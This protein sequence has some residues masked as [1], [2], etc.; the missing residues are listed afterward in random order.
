MS[1]IPPGI[2]DPF[3]L[4]AIRIGSPLMPMQIQRC[5]VRVVVVAGLL[6]SLFQAERLRASSADEIRAGVA[7]VCDAGQ[8]P[9][10]VRIDRAVLPRISVMLRRSATFR[11]QCRRVAGTQRLYIRM[12]VNGLIVSQR[13]RARTRI[14]RFESGVMIAEVELRTPWSPE[15]WI[16]HE[17]EHVLEQIDGVS[18]ADLADRAGG[19]WRTADDMFESERAIRAGRTVVTEMQRERRA[20][21]DGFVE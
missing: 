6:A 18:L 16:A 7:S 8:F 9:Q 12:H 2:A 11:E 1:L 19:A 20:R 10:T 14:F 15:E 17:L 3:L 13:F 4:L 5:C 21:S